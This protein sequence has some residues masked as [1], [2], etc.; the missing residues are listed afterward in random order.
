MTRALLTQG[1]N[2]RSLDSSAVTEVWNLSITPHGGDE[3][4]HA[5]HHYQ[6][7]HS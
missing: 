2:E 1:M 3:E 5:L 7:T 6:Y 4:V